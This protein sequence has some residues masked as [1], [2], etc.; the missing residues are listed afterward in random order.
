[1]ACRAGGVAAHRANVPVAVAAAIPDLGLAVDR[2]RRAAPAQRSAFI[3]DYVARNANALRACL[4]SIAMAAMNAHRAGG[5]RVVIA[6]GATDTLACA[7]LSLAMAKADI[8][9][10]GSIRTLR[11]GGRT[12][13]RHC[14]AEHKMSM[15]R[16][17]GCDAP[18]VRAYSDNTADLPPL[19]AAREPVVM[20]PRPRRV[21][22]LRRELGA[23]VPVLD[24]GGR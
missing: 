19:R 9:I 8:P 23:D 12:T 14:H 17:A 2:D 15:L 7:I 20:N 4:L 10:I 18:I 21:A 1:M 24:W 5:D 16:E 6:T 22:V 13:T 3:A 11:W